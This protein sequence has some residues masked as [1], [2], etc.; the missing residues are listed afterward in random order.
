MWLAILFALAF[1]FPE[2]D[3]GSFAPSFGLH[4]SST[5]RNGAYSKILLLDFACPHFSIP[6]LIALLEVQM[7]SS[8]MRR[9]KI[10]PLRNHRIASDSLP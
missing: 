7:L 1:E 10:L 2:T 9:D 5:S 8:K 4:V 3:S 6:V